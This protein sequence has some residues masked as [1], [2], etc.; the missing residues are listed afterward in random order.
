MPE[1]VKSLI[2]DELTI[3]SVR[4]LLT[5]AAKCGVSIAALM[6]DGGVASLGKVQSAAGGAAGN[7]EEWGNLQ[8]GFST[9]IS[10]L[11][12]DVYL[13]ILGIL[14]KDIALQEM[15]LI[16]N[17]RQFTGRIAFLFLQK[18]KDARR[19]G[20][21][22]SSCDTVSERDDRSRAKWFS[23]YHAY[24]R[25]MRQTL[26]IASKSGEVEYTLL[27]IPARSRT[28][29]SRPEMKTIPSYSF[30]PGVQFLP[31]CFTGLSYTDW[32]S[33]DFDW[34]QLHKKRYMLAAALFFQEEIKFRCGEYFFLPVR[35]LVSYME[36]KYPALFFSETNESS[37]QNDSDCEGEPFSI[38]ALPVAKRSEGSPFQRQEYGLLA[39][40]VKKTAAACCAELSDDEKIV[41]LMSRK[42]ARLKE[43]AA[44]INYKSKSSAS[45]VLES[46]HETVKRHWMLWGPSGEDASEW[47]RYYFGAVI[48]YCKNECRISSQEV[49][50]ETSE[51]P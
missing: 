38:D 5:M 31:Y 33:P 32:P 14:P 48:E 28:D 3:E 49:P 45:T 17:V 25:S 50:M 20:P 44:R 13:F 15:V 7:R 37:Y 24:F 23:P 42:G 35:E 1:D 51:E 43:M 4:S 34:R 18:F 10:A 47:L 11:K 22:D 9:D 39:V 6:G 12:S 30:Y 29:G 46:A 41:L 40:S 27:D 21:R 26:Q 2:T 8:E 19:T 16:G 36:K